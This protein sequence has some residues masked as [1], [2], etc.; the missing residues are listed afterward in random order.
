MIDYFSIIYNTCDQYEF[1]W[2][3]FFTLLDRYWI[4]CNVNIILNTET[5]AFSYKNL[6][7]ERPKFV[8]SCLSWSQRVLNSLNS[9]ETPYVIMML[10]DFWLKASVDVEELFR[11]I[12]LMESDKDINCICFA[13]QP[14]PNKTY[15]NEQK[16]EK[17]GRFARYRVNAQIAL[18]RVEYLKRIMR[19]YENPWQFELSGTFRS[20]LGGGIFLSIKKGIR[21]PFIYD[22]GFLVVRGMLNKEL[23]QYFLQKEGIAI[24]YPIN[25]YK[26]VEYYDKE[27]GRYIRLLGYFKD[28]V[29][30]IF[31]K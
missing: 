31:K 26:A 10:D 2:K 6:I 7:I 9:V 25:E 18:W 5:K 14:E 15:R 17:R 22:Y 11:C 1:L 21:S 4:N 30:S 13:P 29:V 24:N 8:G 12:E 19:T 16:Y 23:A 20:Q 27:R 28:A 3:G